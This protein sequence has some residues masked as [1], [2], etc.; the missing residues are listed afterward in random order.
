MSSANKGR[1]LDAVESLIISPDATSR[2]VEQELN[3]RQKKLNSEDAIKIR[4][5]NQLFLRSNTKKREKLSRLL[6]LTSTKLIFDDDFPF[7]QEELRLRERMKELFMLPT[8]TADVTAAHYIPK[9]DDIPEDDDIRLEEKILRE[10]ILREEMK[11]IQD[12]RF[13]D[14]WKRQRTAIVKLKALHYTE[15]EIVNA[16]KENNILSVNKKN[17][18]QG[19]VNKLYREFL[20]SYKSFQPEKSLDNP[21]VVMGAR[22]NLGDVEE[23]TGP[24]VDLTKTSV[25]N[26]FDAE[27]YDREIVIPF[28]KGTVP[29]DGFF[30]E[31]R[32]KDGFRVEAL[33]FSLKAI[34]N[35]I[36]KIDVVKDTVLIPGIY[37]GQM[38]KSEDDL[39]AKEPSYEFPFIVGVSERDIEGINMLPDGKGSFVPVPDQNFSIDDL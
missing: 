19:A 14:P 26:E 39:K 38:F 37:L 36:L 2:K 11:R 35:G 31:I 13:D 9:D 32:N 29:D 15:A 25:K 34:K 17:I 18:S 4:G 20:D 12:V 7:S 3:K 24:K 22:H 5:V 6:A 1:Q 23:E 27:E 8:R 21:G 28:V 33:Y 10:Q 30:L 16:L